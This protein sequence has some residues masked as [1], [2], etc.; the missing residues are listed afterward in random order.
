[1][2]EE[3]LNRHGEGGVRG[4]GSDPSKYAD[5]KSSFYFKGSTLQEI[6]ELAASMDRTVS[7]VLTRAFKI[8]KAQLEAEA[9]TMSHPNDEVGSSPTM[10]SDPDIDD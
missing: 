6:R 9:R 4:G 2:S 5:R 10:E 7:Y 3:R 8:A 1:M